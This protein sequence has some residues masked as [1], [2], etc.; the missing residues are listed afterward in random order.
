MGE[1][2]RQGPAEGPYEHLL[3]RLSTALDEAN[4]MEVVAER[5]Q[6]ELELRGLTGSELELI[7]AYLDRDLEWLRD[8]H[9]AAKESMEIDRSFRTIKIEPPPGRAAVEFNAMTDEPLNLRLC[10]AICGEP[11][12]WHKA[13]EVQV[14]QGCGSQLFRAESLL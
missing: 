12:E 10:C 8:W 1:L 14:C 9:S 3:Q 7:Q 5:P 11:R 13:A 6:M 4:E 2:K